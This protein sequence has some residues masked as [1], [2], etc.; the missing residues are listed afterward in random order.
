[1]SGGIGYF[2]GL[3]APR[4]IDVD[5]LDDRTRQEL[6]ELL[7]ETDFFRLPAHIATEPG[8]ADHYT[9]RITIE[10]AARH[11]TVNVSDPVSP[12][13]LHR[14]VELLRTAAGGDERSL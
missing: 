3:A 8:S 6:R 2:P 13:P 4:T 14:L 1:M 9:Y 12:P 5:G 7:Q 11:H 10:D